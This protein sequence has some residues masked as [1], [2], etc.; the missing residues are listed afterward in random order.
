METEIQNTVFILR[1]TSP[2][3]SQEGEDALFIKYLTEVTLTTCLERAR[4]KRLTNSVLATFELRAD[5]ER[6]HSGL[7]TYNCTLLEPARIELAEKTSTLSKD[8]SKQNIP[9]P[10]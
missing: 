1:R 10:R 7:R 8:L 9:L 2:L 4:S 3:T 5:D 6:D